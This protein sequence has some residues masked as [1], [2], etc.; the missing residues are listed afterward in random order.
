MSPSVC[1]ERRCSPRS[2]ARLGKPRRRSGG[3]ADRIELGAAGFAHVD[4]VSALAHTDAA[5][6]TLFF[7][8]ALIT[9]QCIG[10]L[11]REA[12]AQAVR[13]WVGNGLGGG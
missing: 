6:A 1:C 11:I 7:G 13:A 5:I 2:A 9:A 10:K 3:L 4:A 12:L 8:R